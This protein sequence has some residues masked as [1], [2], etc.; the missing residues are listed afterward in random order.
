[1][2]LGPLGSRPVRVTM[3]LSDYAQVA[4]GKLYILG[5]GWSITGPAPMPSAI[6]FKLEIDWHE[7]SRPHHWELFLE[8]ADGAPVTI[9]TPEG[10]RA[11]EMRGDVPSFTPLGVAEGSPADFPMAITLG[12]LALPPGGRYTWRLVVDGEQLPGAHVSFATR[13]AEPPATEG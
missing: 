2:R 6:A 10:P 3:L 9:E 4:D 5:G 13:P 12:P 11:V 8:D 1:M 7:T